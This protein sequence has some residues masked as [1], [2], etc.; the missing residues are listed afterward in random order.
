MA[1]AG[2]DVVVALGVHFDRQ[3]TQ[4]FHESLGAQS[5]SWRGAPRGAQHKRTIAIDCA[6][7]FVYA[8]IFFAS[9]GMSAHC[10][11]ANGQRRHGVYDVL[12]GAADINNQRVG[13]KIT[14]Q[15]HAQ[16]LDDDSHWRRQYHDISAVDTAI[17]VVCGAV[18][19]AAFQG[20]IAA[21]VHRCRCR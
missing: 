11:D 7:R 6:V 10:I 5:G 9:H 16:Q 2:Y 17:Q 21:P 3:R 14:A 13:A 19:H 1:D 15:L 20:K 18:D 12:F 8:A 4:R